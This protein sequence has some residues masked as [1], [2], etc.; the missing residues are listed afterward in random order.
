MGVLDRLARAIR[1][2]L[3]KGDSDADAGGGSADSGEGAAEY[4]CSV[5][6]TPVADPD[7]ECPLCRSTDVVPAD[8][9]GENGEP[10]AGSGGSP[11][12]TALAEDAAPTVGDVLSG[13]D[14][15]AAHEDRWHREDGG[16]RVSLPDGGMERAASKDEVRTL[17]FRHYGPPEE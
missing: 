12:E 3:G 9:D 16:Y 2:L 13:R 7:G 14:L 4:R 15:L 5:C 8:G 10:E 17:L 1:R 6:G 11:R